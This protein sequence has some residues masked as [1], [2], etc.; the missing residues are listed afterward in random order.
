MDLHRI[1][2]AEIPQILFGSITRQVEMRLICCDQNTQ[3]PFTIIH[4]V[5]ELSTKIHM[6]I[7]ILFFH[8]LYE[9]DF[10]R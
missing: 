1:V 3:N 4:K 8:F 7:Y 5:Q 9:V 10:V 6:R 2:I